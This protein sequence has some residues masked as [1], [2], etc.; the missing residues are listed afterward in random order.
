[1]TEDVCHELTSQIEFEIQ[2]YLLLECIENVKIYIRATPKKKKKIRGY[3]VRHKYSRRQARFRAP[4][5]LLP[6]ASL[7]SSYV[8]TC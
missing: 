3:F 2:I 7:N 1:M 6:H 5:A 4:I 8:R